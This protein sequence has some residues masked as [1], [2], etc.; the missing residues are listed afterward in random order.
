MNTQK[1]TTFRLEAATE[2]DKDWARDLHRRCYRE[3]IER[4]FG[5]WDADRQRGYFDKKWN[6]LAFQKVI[7]AGDAVG[8]LSFIEEDDHLF[9][10]EIQIDPTAQNRGLGTAILRDLQSRARQTGRFVKLHVLRVSRA[11]ALYQRL[12]FA[13]TE[14]T[15]THLLMQWHPQQAV[16]MFE[17]TILHLIG[18]A[19]TGKRTIAQ[20]I[21]AA[22]PNF[23][24]VDNHF[25]N[26]VIF[27]VIQA[28]GKTKLP[29]QVWDRVGEV[30]DVVLQTIRELSPPSFSFI[31]TNEMIEGSEKD[32]QTFEKFRMTAEARG[33]FYL[34]VR[35][36][37]SVAENRRRIVEPERAQLS[38]TILEEAAIVNARDHE[39]LKPAAVPYISVDVTD[40]S[41]DEAARRILSEAAALR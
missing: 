40:L 1:P 28:D 16:R 4:Q 36:I 9:L 18:F 11:A 22:A 6:P 30:R 2:E 8:I 15:D 35:L 23:R 25:I 10:N 12:G 3:L 17:N 24:L 13:I 31:F 41:P 39:V 20:A 21:V 5:A 14:Q 37:I 26:N 32:Q 29:R 38:K 33:A 7:V 19:G 27:G 34:P